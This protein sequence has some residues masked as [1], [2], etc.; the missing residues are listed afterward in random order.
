M[1]YYSQEY[2]TRQFKYGWTNVPYQYNASRQLAGNI[3][4]PIA[5]TRPR[6]TSY[7]TWMSGKLTFPLK[8]A[9]YSTP[10]AAF[11]PLYGGEGQ[12]HGTVEVH[13]DLDQFIDAALDTSSLSSGN[14]RNMSV[15]IVD[16]TDKSI[17]GSYNT[18]TGASQQEAMVFL[19]SLSG[20]YGSYFMHEHPAVRV[21]ALANQLYLFVLRYGCRTKAYE[22]GFPVGAWTTVTASVGGGY[23]RLYVNGTLYDYA[24]DKRSNTRTHGN[25]YRSGQFFQAEWTIFSFSDTG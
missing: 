19:E 17:L 22:G 5:L 16:N 20:I 21:T 15:L 11:R 23:C 14:L 25:P 12:Y 2:V 7:T 6:A 18:G 4:D 9:R 13:N 8:S 1:N 3:G 24:R 10:M